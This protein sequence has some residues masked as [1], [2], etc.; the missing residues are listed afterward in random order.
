M[1]QDAAEQVEGRLLSDRQFFTS[2][3]QRVGSSDRRVGIQLS[4]HELLLLTL[5]EP[6]CTADLA[7]RMIRNSAGP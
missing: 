1:S 7:G 6:H 3:G 4:P 2:A 5:M